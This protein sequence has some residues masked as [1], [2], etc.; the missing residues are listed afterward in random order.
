M[1]RPAKILLAAL[2]VLCACSSG[3]GLSPLANDAVILAFGDSLTFGTGAGRAES[4]PAVLQNL[5]GRRVI[6]AGVTGEM[7]EAGLE[8][9]PGLLD[10]HRPALLILCH[11]GNDFL[12]KKDPGQLERNLERMIQLAKSRGVEV[13][14]LGVPRPGIFL[15]SDELYARVA[16]SSEVV[17]IEELIADVLGDNA[18]KSDAVHPNQSGYRVMA[19]IIHEVLL[20]NGALQGRPNN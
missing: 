9:L 17:F 5:S 1:W 3:P 20:E 11:G 7:S 18:L 19:Q 14:L 15:S 12:R 13:V 4:Y 8:R 2:F 6:N 10:S 16:A